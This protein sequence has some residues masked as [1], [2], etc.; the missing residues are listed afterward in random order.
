M[1]A[2]RILSVAAVAAFAS[3]SAQ[4]GDLYGADF[5][6][7]FKPSRDRAEVRAEAVQALPNFKNYLPEQ[8][9]AAPSASRDTV[10]AEAITAARAGAIATGNRS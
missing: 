10:R 2:T 5:Q 8:Q 9:V 1:N 7:Q 6:S 4:A 3:I